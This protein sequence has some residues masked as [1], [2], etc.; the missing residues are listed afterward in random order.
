MLRMFHHCIVASSLPLGYTNHSRVRDRT[1]ETSSKQNLALCWERKWIWW[2]VGCKLEAIIYNP[3]HPSYRMYECILHVS[4][5][6]QHP[7]T[8]TRLLPWPTTLRCSWQASR[9][10]RSVF[11]WTWTATK[12]EPKSAARSERRKGSSHHMLR[13]TTKWFQAQK[14]CAWKPFC[15]KT[16]HGHGSCH[17]V[18]G[19]PVCWMLSKIWHNFNAARKCTNPQDLNAH[20][21]VSMFCWHENHI[22]HEL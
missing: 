16:Q 11:I 17:V 14:V 21:G 13:S 5:P 12:V 15:L 1:D 9:D 6:Q 18:V 20:R 8:Q 22:S 7:P 10:G 3:E 4:S 19:T 2:R